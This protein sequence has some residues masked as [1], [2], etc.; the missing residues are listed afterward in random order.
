VKDIFYINRKTGKQEQELVP[1]SKTMFFLYAKPLGKLNL[2]LLFKRKFLSKFSGWLAN[3]EWSGKKIDKF[4]GEHNMDMS[5]FVEPKEGF[6]TFNRF[7]YRHVKPE[8]RPIDDNIVSP[9]DGKVLAFNKISDTQEFF[10]KGSAFNLTTFLKDK[11]LAKKYENGSIMI[12]RLAPADYH[13]YHFPLAGIPSESKK[14][15]GF[16][17]SVSP[18]ALQK[19]MRIFC[20]NKREYTI[21]KNNN[22]GDV[23][24]CD[25]GATL[26][27]SIIQTY[28]PNQPINKGDEK[29]HF[30]FGGSTLILLFEP[31]TMTF[32][33]DLIENT[34]KGFET[35]VLMGEIIGA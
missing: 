22:Y 29:G 24:I 1:G 14:I 15:K 7:F 31:N 6:K 34:K 19:N 16:Y 5:Q 32:S 20:E 13:R 8:A 23:L 3:T 4:I 27:G 18:L 26:T 17:Y 33:E 9:A 25:V 28:K 30:A 35:T 12:V 2:F 21:L 10:V 11:E